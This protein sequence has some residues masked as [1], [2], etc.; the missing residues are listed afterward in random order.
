ML[1]RLGLV[2][3]VSP[4]LLQLGAWTATHRRWAGALGTYLAAITMS[5]LT[6]ADA[7]I[8]FADLQRQ[9]FIIAI[10]IGLSL[11]LI[12]ARARSAFTL[13]S[14]AVAVSVAVVILPLY[15][16]FPGIPLIGPW[17]EAFKGYADEVDVLLNP[18]SFVGLLALVV[19]IS[20]LK[21]RPAI[22]VAIFVPV[23][24]AIAASGSRTTLVSLIVAIPLT[25]MFILIHRRPVIPAWIPYGV[26]GVI[27]AWAS[28]TFADQLGRLAVSPALE[29]LTTGRSLLWNAAWEKFLDR[30]L[31][32]WG[33]G[34]FSIDLGQYLPGVGL[35]RAEDLSVLTTAGG[36]HNALL[37]VLAERGLLAAVAAGLV[38]LFLLNLAIRLYR[39]RD[40]F[41]GMDRGLATLAPFVV[42]LMLVR[43]LGELPGWFG[44]ADSLIDFL[45]YGIAA[46][47]VAVAS[48]LDVTAQPSN[49]TGSAM[50]TDS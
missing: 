32:G 19:A 42:I 33:A 6:S 28:L 3:A 10:A 40:R 4:G 37:N 15:S 23:M 12:D 39:S 44:S 45:A 14:V 36:A 11:A 17:Q 34:S 48:T 8:A 31:F 27:A 29:D 24:A 50:T 16:R 46:L 30:P 18:L 38:A 26:V 5:A 7:A 20:A 41:R 43:S 49:K 1:L 25:G 21:H 13:A 2:V 35:Y 9:V 47:L 22:L